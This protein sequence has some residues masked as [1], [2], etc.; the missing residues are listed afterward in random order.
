MDIG[1]EGG[2]GIRSGVGQDA[3]QGEDTLCSL[4]LLTSPPKA[5]CKA[6]L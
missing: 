5:L 2:S 3:D 4:R 1:I 6:S